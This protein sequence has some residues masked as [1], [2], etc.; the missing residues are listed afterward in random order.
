MIRGYNHNVFLC[1]RSTSPHPILCPQPSSERIRALTMVKPQLPKMSTYHYFLRHLLAFRTYPLITASWFLSSCQLCISP[2]FWLKSL[3][4]LP[5]KL[6][7]HLHYILV[8]F[9]TSYLVA[10]TSLR[11]QRATEL[12]GTRAH[13]SVH[14]S[15]PQTM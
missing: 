7:L 8:T 14:H 3:P 15:L 2:S 10:T 9:S 6:G 5:S 4:P 11:I 13:I 1:S 12:L